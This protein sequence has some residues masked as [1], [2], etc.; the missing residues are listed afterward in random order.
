[1]IST[2]VF[3]FHGF[4]VAWVVVTAMV[5]VEDWDEPWPAGFCAF[6]PCLLY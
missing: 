5:A 2:G 6:I 1:M 3:F 4:L